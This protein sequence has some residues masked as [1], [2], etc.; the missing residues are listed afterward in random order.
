MAHTMQ[1]QFFAL[2]DHAC[3]ALAGGEVLLVNVAAEA[4][5]FV[6]FNHGRV[7]QPMTVHQATLSLALI[8]GKRRNAITLELTGSPEAD[9][10]LVTEALAGLRAELPSLPEDDLLLY[11]TEATTSER[12]ERGS[13]PQPEQAIEDIVAAAA[14][15]DLVGILASG[16]MMRGFASSF[17][18]R[19]WHEV[20]AY[21]FDWSLYHA[22][23]KAVKCSW[24][25]SSWDRAELQRQIDAGREQLAH[26]AKPARTLQPGGYRAFLAPAA[27][28]ELLWMFNWGGVSERAQRTKQSCLQRLADGE[29]T[30]SP[31]VSLVEDT[32]RGLAP[33]F[34]DVGFAR[35]AKVAL[36]EG[37][38]HVGAMVS[39]RTGKQYGIASN[40]ADEA[41]GMESGSLAP[42]ALPI[43]DALA[44]LDTGIYIGN[45]H[46]LNFSDR[47]HGRIT[48]MTRFATFWVEGGRIVAPVNVMRWDD[49]LYRMLGSNLEALTSDAPLIL[50]NL[51]YGQRSTLTSRVPGALLKDMTFTL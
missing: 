29:A 27:V 50:N 40:G 25:G 9:R 24:S 49:T 47:A 51:T 8:Q 34:S 20:S 21:L 26:L 44:A 4:T 15:T 45:L 41:E 23:D 3:A 28:D 1:A 48:G 33:A 17:G 36:V 35:P 38:R 18:A 42:G 13:L 46:Y 10:A 12:I 19:H 32:A 39:P 31:L 7:R 30:L 14:G 22:T 11:S 6:R 16:P 2:A 5:D 37:G 43:T